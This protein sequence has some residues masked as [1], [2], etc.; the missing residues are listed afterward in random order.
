MDPKL[1]PATVAAIVVNYGTPALTIACVE[2]LLR[3]EGTPLH[4]IVVDNASRDDSVAQ[5][6]ARFRDMPSVTIHAR[7][8]NDGYTGGNNAG[9]ALATR[10]GAALAF[11]LNSDTIVDPGCVR[12]L[13]AEL[14]RDA[15]VAVACPRILFGDPPERLWFG[16]ARFS[17]WTGRPAHVGWQKPPA[18]GWRT[19]RDLPFASG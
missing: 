9:I 6:D 17:L 1:A 2:S 3:A 7:Q 14:A 5:L 12:L 4:V 10:R 13:V 15:D 8:R 19:P 18:A 16:G 11:V